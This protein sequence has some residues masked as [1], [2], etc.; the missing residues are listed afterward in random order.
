MGVEAS[1]LQR[2]MSARASAGGCAPSGGLA[3]FVDGA[4]FARMTPGGHKEYLRLRD[5]QSRCM[6]EDAFFK[7]FDKVLHHDVH[8]AQE[9]QEAWEAAL[10][11]RQSVASE[12]LCIGIGRIPVRL[13]RELGY[14]SADAMIDDARSGQDA[15]VRQFCRWVEL[16]GVLIEVLRCG[17]LHY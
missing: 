16:D 8:S 9:V 11:M 5:L 7:R 3:F 1:A 13:W 17:L 14:A 4:C 15:Q 6:I 10:H 12:C 2:L